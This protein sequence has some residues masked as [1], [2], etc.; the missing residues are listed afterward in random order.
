M[1]SKWADNRWSLHLR[2]GTRRQSPY[3]PLYIGGANYVLGAAASQE[4]LQTLNAPC[5]Q[6][7]IDSHAQISDE[8]V[9]RGVLL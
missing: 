8:N 7:I 5:N 3:G 4:Q 2:G 9:I 1:R 6:N